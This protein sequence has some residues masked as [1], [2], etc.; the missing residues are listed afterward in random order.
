MLLGLATKAEARRKRVVEEEV[1]Q[2]EAEDE[3]PKASRRSSG[4]RE[5]FA[6]VRLF[7]GW[8]FGLA[9]QE[10]TQ[11][12]VSPANGGDDGV[13]GNPGSGLLGGAEAF[14]G[15]GASFEAGLSV[16]PF[17]VKAYNF[18]ETY[19]QG[20]NGTNNRTR[21]EALNSTAVFFSLYAAHSFGKLRLLGGWGLGYAFGGDDVL[22]STS[23]WSGGTITPGEYKTT[24]TTPIGGSF[25]TRSFLGA[26][27]SFSRQLSVLLGTS[28]LSANFSPAANGTSTQV[29]TNPSGSTTTTSIPSNDQTKVTTIPVSQQS[30][31]VG[32]TFRI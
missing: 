5:S 15:P 26:E 20:T 21:T 32:L 27:W 24:V 14:Y 11:R 23:N 22:V 31:L 10:W 28:L 16:I 19:T 4:G 6:G 8:G 9:S 2:E 17:T 18:S 3:A 25:A 30:V 7:A 13:F 29:N 1:S 12:F